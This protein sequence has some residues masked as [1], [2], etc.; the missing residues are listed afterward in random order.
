MWCKVYFY[1]EFKSL[2]PRN[3]YT[4]E[5]DVLFWWNHF[6]CNGASKDLYPPL[7]TKGLPKIYV[8]RTLRRCTQTSVSEQCGIMCTYV[9]TC[10]CWIIIVQRN[11]A[12]WACVNVVV[13]PVRS[14][15]AHQVSREG[16]RRQRRPT[17]RMAVPGSSYAYLHSLFNTYWSGAFTLMMPWI[18][19]AHYLFV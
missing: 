13:R 5:H 6:K 17:T 18:M 4:H 7:T 19:V 11:V 10:R 3:A 1:E 12:L 14:S 8:V 16:L 9:H 15:A 2:Q